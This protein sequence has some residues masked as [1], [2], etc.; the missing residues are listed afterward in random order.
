[1][2]AVVTVGEEAALKYDEHAAPLGRKVNFPERGT[3]NT[4]TVGKATKKKE[5]I[6]KKE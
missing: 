6:K 1:M 3:V 5:E 2:P 4:T